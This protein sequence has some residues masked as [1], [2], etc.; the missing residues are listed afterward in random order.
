[1]IFIHLLKRK[2]K[3]ILLII[4]TCFVFISV[5]MHYYSEFG[6]I[7]SDEMIL[8][9]KDTWMGLSLFY[10]MQD[11]GFVLYLYLLMALLIPN[12]L[13]IDFLKYK[14][15]HFDYMLKTRVS[16]KKYIRKTR[17][18]NFI[19]TFSIIFMTHLIVLLFIHLFLFKIGFKTGDPD[20]RRVNVFYSSELIS[21]IIYI[22]FSSTGYA[23]FS[24]FLYSLQ[25]FITNTYLYRLTGIICSIGLYLGSAV[26]TRLLS[27]INVPDLLLHI[28]NSL[29]IGNLITPGM[30]KSV[31]LNTSPYLAFMG[32]VILYTLISNIIYRCNHNE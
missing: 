4:Y 21:L 32:S 11:A 19:T 17:L 1:M 31:A 26:I 2:R 16:L 3:I 18:S 10:E 6:K 25:L 7:P 9:K 22:I 23:V 27:F 28:T 14:R 8:M 15:N 20:I 12:I 5:L 30:Y 29:S 13:S 24:D